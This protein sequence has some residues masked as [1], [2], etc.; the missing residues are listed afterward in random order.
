MEQGGQYLSMQDG[1]GHALKPIYRA[2]NAGLVLVWPVV[3]Q[4]LSL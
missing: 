2:R 1:A 4:V 3:L